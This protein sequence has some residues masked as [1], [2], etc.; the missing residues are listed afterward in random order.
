MTMKPVPLHPHLDRP[1]APAPPDGGGGLDLPRRPRR[2]RRRIVTAIGVAAVVVVAGTLVVE[3]LA[4]GVPAIDR[5]ELRIGTVARGPLDL[6]VDGPGTLVPEQIRWISAPMAG[7]V[8]RVLA[9]PGAEVHADTVL[10][11]LSNPDAE[12]AAL[13][14]DRE[15]AAAR[16]ALT[17]LRAKLDGEV[18]AQRSTV[19]TLESDRTLA[20]H[21]ARI[22]AEM[23]TKGVVAELDAE[24]SK[25]RSEQLTSRVD[26]EQRRLRALHRSQAAQLQAQQD[27]ITRLQAIADFRHRQLDDLRLRAGVDGVLQDLPLQVGQSVVAGAPCAKVVRP[28]RLKAVLRVPELAARDVA[29]GQHAIVDLRATKVEGTVARIDPA[30]VDGT[31]KVD[32]ALAAPLPRAARPELNVDGTIEL[33][34]TGDVLHVPR[35]ALGDA[36]GRS[37]VWKVVGDHAVRVPVTFGRA[38]LRDIEVTSG[39]AAGDRIVLS[40]MSRW[41]GA[42]RVDLR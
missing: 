14:A 39:L 18:L 22:D 30:A 21:R 2:R 42:D 15:V 10:L 34:R 36:H 37:L 4:S 28:D 33:E 1:P 38:S 31:V 17:T 8:V 32:V 23:R 41:D 16:V 5:D 7:R 19:S 25:A 6:E 29:I 3:H 40:D 11:E 27:E 35:P 12:L 13:D 9:E 24:E 20:D 26:F